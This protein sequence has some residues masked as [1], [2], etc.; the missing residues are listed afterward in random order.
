MPTRLRHCR[1]HA[2]AHGKITPLTHIATLT[3]ATGRL[4]SFRARLSGTARRY[5]PQ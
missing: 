5:R 2:A 4:H 3:V 1:Y